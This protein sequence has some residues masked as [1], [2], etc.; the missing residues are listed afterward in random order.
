[1]LQVL[2]RGVQIDAGLVGGERGGV[3]CWHSAQLLQST[4]Q[5]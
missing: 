3:A 5:Q 4:T 1:M 2:G